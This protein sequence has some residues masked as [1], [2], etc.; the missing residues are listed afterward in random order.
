MKGELLN[1]A[2][3][4]RFV[5]KT[6]AAQRRA[7]TAFDRRYY[8]PRVAKRIVGRPDSPQMLL[9]IGSGKGNFGDALQ[10]ALPENSRVVSTDITE[11]GHTGKTPYI[12]S[13]GDQLPFGDGTF[14]ISTL[15]YVLHH[16]DDPVAALKE[17]K[18]VGNRVVVQEDTYRRRW[19]KRLI[20]AH[21]RG[22]QVDSPG[23]GASVHTDAEWQQIFDAAGLEIAEKH[24]IH[25]LGYPAR[26]YE[27]HLQPKTEPEVVYPAETAK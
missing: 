3:E 2:I 20:D 8:L 19:Q 17:A 27:Y 4:S 26:R 5:R 10:E 18:R 22:Y 16:I 15:L 9:D 1:K 7:V 12:V 14:D 11:K 25:K 21:V 23:M 24:R 13:R 6:L